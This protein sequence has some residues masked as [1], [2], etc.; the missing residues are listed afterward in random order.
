MPSVK[1]QAVNCDNSPISKGCR[2]FTQVFAS[3]TTKTKEI[4]WSGHQGATRAPNWCPCDRS[5][6]AY[7]APRHCCREAWSTRLFQSQDWRWP[8]PPTKSQFSPPVHGGWAYPT[9]SSHIPATLTEDQVA[10]PVTHASQSTS[11]EK[12]PLRQHPLWDFQWQLL[13]HPKG[14]FRKDREMNHYEHWLSRKMLWNSSILCIRNVICYCYRCHT[15]AQFPVF[16]FYFPCLQKKRNGGCHM[17]MPP[18]IAR[19]CCMLHI[20]NSHIN[21]LRLAW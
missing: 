11:P 5:A 1:R 21:G 10:H 8:N 19:V 9:R 7:M 15:Q 13:R 18:W 6:R 17:H 2:G 20:R 3:Q 12:F 14:E 4:P 16:R